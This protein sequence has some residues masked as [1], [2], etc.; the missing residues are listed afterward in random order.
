[1]AQGKKKS[2]LHGKVLTKVM[3]TDF[4]AMH[5]GELD[6]S[7]YLPSRR[8]NGDWVPGEWL[9]EIDEPSLCDNGYH[10]TNDPYGQWYGD[11]GLVF[12]AEGRLAYDDGGRGKGQTDGDKI[13]FSQIR[14]LRP[15]AKTA[16]KLGASAG[17]AAAPARDVA[18][19][20]ATKIIGAPFLKSPLGTSAPTGSVACDTYNEAL[21]E[22]R[23]RG[24]SSGTLGVT[25]SSSSRAKYPAGLN[26]ANARVSKHA[27][28]LGHRTAYFPT[29]LLSLAVEADVLPAGDAR[30]KQID[31]AV[32]AHT[33]GF[34][35]AGRTTAG[36]LIIY[37]RA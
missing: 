9:P 18:D 19:E 34:G 30:K 3:S 2:S 22:L 29:N 28:S 27:Q 24:S 6:Y 16:T 33:A 23:A 36:D 37:R 32:A 25:K 5:G 8:I 4:N 20:L 35:V 15:D 10:L 26:A 11:R 21:Y 17:A 12:E 7:D 31:E 13:S 1:M 14:L